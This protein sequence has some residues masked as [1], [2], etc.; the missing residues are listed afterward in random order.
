M[1]QARIRTDFDGVRG[2]SVTAT[3]RDAAKRWS[4]TAASSPTCGGRVEVA[5]GAGVRRL[6][7][8]RGEAP[9]AARAASMSI[10]AHWLIPQG[11]VARRLAARGVPYLVTSHGG[12]L[13]GLRG[14]LL[15][16]LKRRVAG[17]IVGDDRR[18]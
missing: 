6:A 11:L 1:R 5:A 9:A 10:H 18:E 7:V 14:R 12:D 17:A 2:A 8:A 13:F 3:R 15:E 16:S 4:T